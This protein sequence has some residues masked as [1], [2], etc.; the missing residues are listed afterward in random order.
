MAFGK[1]KISKRVT[2]LELGCY[3]TVNVETPCNAFFS[4]P[5]ST[6]KDNTVYASSAKLERKVEKHLTSIN[7]LNEKEQTDQTI[8]PY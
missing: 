1:N 5:F 2:V 6:I 8:K 3:N 4:Y 7:S